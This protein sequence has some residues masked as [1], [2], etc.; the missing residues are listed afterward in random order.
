MTILQPDG[1]FT[2]GTPPV[3]VEAD[4]F[5]SDCGRRHDFE[6]CPRCGAWIEI[7]YGIGGL[8]KW[9]AAECGWGFFR[10]D[11]DSANDLTCIHGRA[12]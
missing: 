6:K 12:F 10:H 11:S 5:C 2:T 7:Q 9:C 4:R 1:Y 8:R 3:F